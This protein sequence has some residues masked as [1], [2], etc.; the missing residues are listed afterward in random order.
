MA[1]ENGWIAIQSRPVKEGA[2]SQQGKGR[3]PWLGVGF[4]EVASL[5]EET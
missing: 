2:L 3:T 5:P 4:N 1:L